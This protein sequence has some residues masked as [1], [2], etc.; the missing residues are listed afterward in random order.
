VT[1]ARAW[2]VGVDVGGT[3]TDV[4]LADSAG[5]V[6]IGKVPTTPDDPRIGVVEAIRLVL[7]RVGVAHFEALAASNCS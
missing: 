5:G 7:D 4:V 3:F 2:F 1:G 6:S